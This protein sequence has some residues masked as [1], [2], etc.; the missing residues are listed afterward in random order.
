MTNIDIYS[1]EGIKFQDLSLDRVP[2]AGEYLILDD[3][4]YSILRVVWSDC[5]KVRI[6]LSLPLGANTEN[7]NRIFIL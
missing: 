1:N 5:R 3:I 2:N 6:Q 4:V 7:Q